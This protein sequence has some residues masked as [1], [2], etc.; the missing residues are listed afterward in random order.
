MLAQRVGLAALRRGTP[1]IFAQAPQ[2]II[3]AAPQIRP[4]TTARISQQDGHDILVKQRLQR[5]VS[6]HLAIYKIEQTWLGHSAWTRITGCALSGAAY[7]YFSA[8]LVAPLLGWHLESASLASGFAAL[9]FAVKGGVKF[10][11]GFPFAYH[12]INGLR[13]LWFDLGKGFAKASIRKGET[14]LW[15]ASVASGLYLAFGL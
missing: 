12:F 13:H 9:P 15:T 14:A 10:A 1:S 2:A 11:L 5:P 8:Y 4:V 7:A 3:T 6:P